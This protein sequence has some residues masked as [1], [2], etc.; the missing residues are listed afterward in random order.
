M[1]ASAPSSCCAWQVSMQCICSVHVRMQHTE[2]LH[3]SLL[4]PMQPA[5]ECL[6]LAFHLAQRQRVGRD[7][8]IPKHVQGPGS[9]RYRPGNCVHPAYKAKSQRS[10]TKGAHAWQ[11][12]CAG[13]AYPASF[14]SLGAFHAK[15]MAMQSNLKHALLSHAAVR[16]CAD[17]V[18][19]C[20][21][22]YT[23]FC[24]GEAC[25]RT[26]LRSAAWIRSQHCSRRAGAIVL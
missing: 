26:C 11:A 16:M 3:L 6:H 18:C 2:N 10:K 25:S 22:S 7:Q 1:V 13:R 23:H 17:S 12:R 14:L 8:V 24:N 20:E 21:I 15:H 4:H 19:L 5:A 9:D